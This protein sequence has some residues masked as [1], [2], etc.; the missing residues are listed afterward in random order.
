[1]GLEK[2]IH[3]ISVSMVTNLLPWQPK[4][5]FGGKYRVVFTEYQLNTEYPRTSYHIWSLSIHKWPKKVKRVKL[6]PR[7]GQ[8]PIGVSS[9]SWGAAPNRSQG[10]LPIY[11]YIFMY[12]PEGTNWYRIQSFLG[13]FLIPDSDS[14]K[15]GGYR[16]EYWFEVSGSDHNLL[17]VIIDIA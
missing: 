3:Q 4:R 2:K 7:E 6:A 10:Q 16:F 13:W 11:V 5:G 14:R 15:K 1:M 17:Q 12:N 8:L 9:P